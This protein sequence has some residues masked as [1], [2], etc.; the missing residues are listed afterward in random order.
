MATRQ[1]YYQLAMADVAFHREVV[2]IAG[3]ETVRHLWEGTARQLV[4]I[5]G[6][7]TNA[8]DIRKVYDAV[9]KG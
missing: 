7:T 4:I 6:L 5:L 1:D 8:E 3:N 9:E 2:E